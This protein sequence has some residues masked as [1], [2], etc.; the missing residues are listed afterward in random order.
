MLCEVKMM[1]GLLLVKCAEREVSVRVLGNRGAQ[2]CG[3]GKSTRNRS[4]SALRKSA[5]LE[6]K[7]HPIEE[8]STPIHQGNLHQWSQ[9]L[10]S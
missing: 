8:V 6:R 7:L 3:N 10:R 1:K 5:L 9:Q 2:V 4:L